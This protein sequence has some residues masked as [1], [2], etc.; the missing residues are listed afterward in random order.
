[1][2][3]WETVVREFGGD[4]C[5]CGSAKQGGQYFCRACYFS[6]PPEYRSRLWRPWRRMTQN[7]ICTLYSRCVSKL[8]LKGA[9]VEK[10]S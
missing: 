7:A 5:R 3:A 8:G 2:I 9:Q 4:E 10:A 6:L 1:M